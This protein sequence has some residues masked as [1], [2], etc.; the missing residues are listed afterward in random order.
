MSWVR[1]WS[2]RS[3]AEATLVRDALAHEA[4][5]AKILGEGRASLAGEIPFPETMTEVLVEEVCAP[6]ARLLLARAAVE[7]PDWRCA[8]CG[9]ENPGNFELCWKCG[10]EA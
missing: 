2:G 5:P 6:A 10:R 4:I 3:L 1:V 8:G 9:E 7:A